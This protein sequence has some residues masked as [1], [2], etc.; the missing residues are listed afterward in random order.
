MPLPE[1]RLVMPV[2]FKHLQANQKA[3]LELETG[4]QMTAR[5]Y[6]TV[7]LVTGFWRPGENYHERIIEALKNKI[8]EG[9]VVTVSE[10][11]I[12]TA[13]GNLVDEKPIKASAAAR[14]LARYWMR[15]AWAHILGTLCHLR[16]KTIARFRNYPSEEG[17][18]HKQL[19][20]ERAGLLQALM[21][22]SEG[23]IDG[24]NVPYSYVSIPLRDHK[25]IAEQIRERIR[26]ELRINVTVMIVDT[27]KTYSYRNFHFT[28]RPNPIQGIQ[29]CGGVFAYVF[30]RFFRL[31]TRSTPIALSGSEMSTETALQIAE[32]ANRTRGYGAGRNVWDM[33]ETFHV[34]LT[35]VTWKMLEEI[36]HKP[37][38][39]VRLKRKNT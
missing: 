18:K 14:F 13:T 30:G 10:K 27:D 34:H 7:A 28:P 35:E 17:S 5:R 1:I 31:E 36:E 8:Q 4:V 29:S 3:T 15:M 37:I 11:A 24:S 32:T 20:L 39:I 2:I 23:G 38:V 19:V 22:G 6:Q 26:T 16:S 21:H 12:S 25:R 9:D 33:A